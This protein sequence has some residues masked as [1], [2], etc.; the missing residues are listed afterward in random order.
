M[1]LGRGL[2]GVR[3]SDSHGPKQE[4]PLASGDLFQVFALE[5]KTDQYVPTHPEIEIIQDNGKPRLAP[6]VVV[7]LAQAFTK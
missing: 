6:D 7:E 1:G 3:R 5:K 2:A 4:C